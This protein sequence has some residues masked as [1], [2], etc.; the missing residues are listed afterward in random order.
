MRNFLYAACTRV[1]SMLRWACKRARE[2]C[3]VFLWPLAGSHNRTKFMFQDSQPRVILR[4]KKHFS[5]SFAAI[6]LIYRFLLIS[7][8]RAVI[9]EGT[10]WEGLGGPVKAKAAGGPQWQDVISS[11]SLTEAFIRNGNNVSHLIIVN[12]GC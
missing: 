3:L 1:S 2:V 8:R 4:R 6:V 5:K 10:V 9:W 7:R 12:I 11:M